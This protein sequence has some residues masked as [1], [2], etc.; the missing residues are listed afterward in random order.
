MLDGGVGWERRS[1]EEEVTHTRG[2]GASPLGPFLSRL[3]SSQLAD[4]TEKHNMLA[5][6]PSAV[7]Y[8]HIL[9]TSG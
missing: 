5:N 1:G 6:I 2:V 7:P 4:G 8:H 3:S 9:R